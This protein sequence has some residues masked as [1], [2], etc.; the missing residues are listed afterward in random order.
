DVE[1]GICDIAGNIQELF[2]YSRSEILT[3][4]GAIWK[5]ILHREDRAR[6]MRRV[7]TLWRVPKEFS[8]EFRVVNKINGQIH[9]VVARVV[10]L[11]SSSGT[12]D[13]WEG[14]AV[15]ITPRRVAQDALVLQSKRVAALYSVSKALQFDLDPAVVMLKGLRSLID[16]TNSDCGLC[17]TYDR[18]NDEIELSAAEG[19]SE[20]YVR[21]VEGKIN[22]AT[23]VREVLVSGEAIKL[24]NIQKDPRAISRV[25]EVEGL[26]STIIAPL[27]FENF[28]IG[29]LVLFCH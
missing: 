28:V 16:A 29:V 2:G 6:L 15:D 1:F 18:E 8:E 27:K 23:L 19:L 22:A 13:G 14:I 9:W 5:D 20:G 11:F 26:R 21:G 7:R 3:K 10:P 17:L 24:D 25:A 4:S 12:L